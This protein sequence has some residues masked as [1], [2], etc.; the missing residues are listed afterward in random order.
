MVAGGYAITIPAFVL[1]WGAA[2]LAAHFAGE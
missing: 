1:M 2:L